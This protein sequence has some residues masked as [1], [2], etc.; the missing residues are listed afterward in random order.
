MEQPNIAVVVMDTARATDTVP[1][2]PSVT[3]TLAEL[4]DD[5][6]AYERTFTSAPWTLPSHASMFTGTYSSKHGAHGDH[7]YLEDGLTTLAETFSAAG[8]ETVGV[9]SNTWLTEEFGFARGFESFYRT[10]QFIQSGTDLGELTRIKHSSGKVDAFLSR[11][12]EGNPLVN[13]ANA[14]YDQFVRGNH[15]DGAERATNMLDDWLDE[16]EGDRP[17]FCFANY[18]EPHVEY[19]PPREVAER[20]LP[21]GSYETAREIRQQPRAY[22]VGE[23]DLTET[24]FSLLRGLYR[25]ELAYLDSQIARLR[26][27]LREAGEWEDTVLV[28]CGDHG[29]NVGD[30]GF[31]GHQYNLY[32]TLLHV[33]LIVHGGGFDPAADEDEFVQ[34]L[35]LF[36]TLLDVACVDAPAAREQAQGRSLLTRSEPRDAVFAEYVAPQPSMEQLEERFGEVPEDVY[37]YDRSLRAVR[38]DEYKYIR[39]SDGLQELYDVKRDPQETIDLAEREPALVEEFDQRLDAW[40]DSFDHTESSGDVEMAQATKGR[41]RDLGYL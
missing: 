31:F 37:E 13:G 32:D 36:P 27:A 24:E 33:P 20:F 35:D 19:S 39:G 26:D 5:G 29:E 18:I 9:S 28:V 14:L 30:H 17:F 38:T 22:D 6:V 7:T 11:L 21:E 4:A 8:Y 12:L 16:R 2:D 15:D 41:L 3:P 25:G 1:A 40:V 23:Y 34:L 10:W